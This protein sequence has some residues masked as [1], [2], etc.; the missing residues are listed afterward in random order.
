VNDVNSACAIGMKLCNTA[1]F[2]TYQH[3]I[4]T[5]PGLTSRGSA[6]GWFLQD[7]IS[8]LSEIHALKIDLYLH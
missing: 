7:L 6:L 8:F 4:R 3:K 2:K 5:L 1:H